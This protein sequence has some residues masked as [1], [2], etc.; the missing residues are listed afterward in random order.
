MLSCNDRRFKRARFQIPAD[1]SG[2][3][4]MNPTP[5]AADA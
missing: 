4:R 3:T 5:V 2:A 1:A